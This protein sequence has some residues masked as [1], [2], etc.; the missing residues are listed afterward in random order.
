MPVGFHH[1]GPLFAAGRLALATEES[2]GLG[3]AAHVP[4]RDGI[5]ASLLVAEMVAVEGATLDELARRLYARHGTLVSRRVQLPWR[6]RTRVALQRLLARK[7]AS[8]AG[9]PVTRVDRGDG[10]LLEL[11]DGSW[12]LVRPSGTE[13]KLRIYAEA[14]NSRQLRTLVSEAHRLVRAGEEG[15]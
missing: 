11:A 10:V 4:E 13:K 7:F 15:G 6:E 2:A 5:Y 1:F 12:V 3:V 8:F 14:A 9:Q